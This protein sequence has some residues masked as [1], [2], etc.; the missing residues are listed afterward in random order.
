[1]LPIVLGELYVLVR[2]EGKAIGGTPGTSGGGHTFEDSVSRRI[3]G[4][5]KDLGFRSISARHTLELPTFSGI[6]HQIDCS[7]DIADISYLLEC[8]RRKMSTKDQIHYFNSVIADYTLGLRLKNAN[9]SVK[10]IFLS[11]AAIDDNSL[12][13]SLAYGL[14]IIDPV[15]PPLELL[16]SREKDESLKS[17]LVALRE[18]IP[19]FNPLHYDRLA[20]E[21]APETLLREYKFLLSHVEMAP[22]E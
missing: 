3:H 8:K 12:A 6:R 20:Q 16:I 2:R 7:F 15:H 22:G 17:A 5:S 4:L 19:P 1:M 13:Y 9:R 10:G 14:S 18:K 21:V 11:T